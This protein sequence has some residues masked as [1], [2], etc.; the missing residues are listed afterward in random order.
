M[1]SADP[2]GAASG[3]GGETVSTA[4]LCLYLFISLGVTYM[5]GGGIVQLIVVV[6]FFLLSIGRPNPTPKYTSDYVFDHEDL[7]SEED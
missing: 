3:D 6:I 2:N 4:G 7:D 5:C 1:S